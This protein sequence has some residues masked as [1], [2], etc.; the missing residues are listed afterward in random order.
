[1]TVLAAAPAG[2]F[3]A[4]AIDATESQYLEP[5][6]GV[7]R[8]RRVGRLLARGLT[9]AVGVDIGHLARCRREPQRYDRLAPEPDPRRGL[10]V[11]DR[12][13]GQLT[14]SRLDRGGAAA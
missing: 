12:P 11:D 6:L 9:L 8:A 3:S 1:M 13:L 14:R 4:N 5:L 2:W 10:L 7:V